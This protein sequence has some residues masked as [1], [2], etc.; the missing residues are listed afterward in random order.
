[1]T[2]KEILD[3]LSENECQLFY[4]MCR[5]KDNEELKAAHAAARL[6]LETF[7]KAT[8]FIN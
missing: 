7:A 1:M 4:A 5:D 8:G 3:I 6:A 2:N